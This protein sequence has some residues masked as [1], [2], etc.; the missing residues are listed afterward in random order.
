MDYLLAYLHLI[1]VHFKGQDKAHTFISGMN[2]LET[3]TDIVKITIA[4]KLQVICGYIS[5][6]ILTF[7]LDRF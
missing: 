6:A 1:L 3:V 7:D 4:I 5:N 2:I